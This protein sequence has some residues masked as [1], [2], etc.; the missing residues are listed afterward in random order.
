MSPPKDYSATTDRRFQEAIKL[1]DE[2]HRDD[3]K[4]VLVE[5]RNMPWSLLYHQRMSHWVS[6]LAPQAS[7]SLR[8]AARCQHLRRWVIPRNTYPMNRA[9]Y[10]R[11]R[12][13]LSQFHVENAKKILGQVGYGKETICRVGDLIQ[14][15]GLKLDPEVQLFEDAIC[16]VFLENELS[17]FAQKHSSD[18]LIEILRKTWKKMSLDGHRVALQLARKLPRQ[19]STLLEKALNQE[20]N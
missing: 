7:V 6:H 15:R 13:T 18:K 5:G 1:F 10:K 12:K 16:L 8:L 2:A 3:P 14:K 19:V 4:E 20:L 17:D 11:W 9:G